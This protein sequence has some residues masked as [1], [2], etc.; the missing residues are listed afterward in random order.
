MASKAELSRRSYQ[1]HLAQIEK[2][3]E[4]SLDEERAT[5]LLRR[6]ETVKLKLEAIG[7]S[8]YDHTNGEDEIEKEL[9]TQAEIS[10]KIIGIEV[11]LETH[12]AKIRKQATGEHSSQQPSIQPSNQVPD[13]KGLPLLSL[14]K[15]SGDYKE[16]RP[17][18]DQFLAAVGNRNISNVRKFAYLQ[19]CL[20]GEPRDI[21]N[22]LQCTD[23]NY[24]EGVNLL[25]KRYG[26]SSV[27]IALYSDNVV[28]LPLIQEGNLSQLRQVMNTFETSMR[29]LMTLLSETES[30]S[31]KRKPLHDYLLASLLIGKLPLSLR[32]PMG[33][34]E[35]K[36]D[37]EV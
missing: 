26:D 6:T 33:S 30:E 9:T 25:K 10:G 12:I 5:I 31:S 18:Y 19:T 21:L 20:T 37:R 15:F 16:W 14:P 8:I 1:G 28:K 13:E 23:D 29:E 4:S 2:E 34:S 32:I 11:H 17:F 7:A 22:G 36:C 27:L 3:M 24:E 35:S